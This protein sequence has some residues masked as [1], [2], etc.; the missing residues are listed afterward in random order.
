MIIE[1]KTGITGFVVGFNEEALLKKS[2]T[3]LQG[4]NQLIYVDLNS[5]DNSVEVAKSLS[6]SVIH[7]DRVP[8]VEII[9][10]KL[11]PVCAYDWIL[12]TDPD[13][14]VDEDLKTQLMAL[15]AD[16]PSDIGMVI[17][18]WRFYFKNHPLKGT[19]W[20]GKNYRVV[21]I[22]RN[23]V[24]FSAQVHRGRNLVD[25]FK[26]YV[27]EENGNN[28]I[29]HYWMLSYKQLI[30][31]HRRYIKREGESMYSNGYRFNLW[32]FIKLPVSA[33]RECFIIKKGYKDG[34]IGF[35]LSLFWAWYKISAYISLY[36]FQK[37]QEQS[38]F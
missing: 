3:N 5:S 36:Q 34:I 31:K 15:A 26:Q 18:P 38:Q 21:L 24:E 22:N 8:I 20:G 4:L 7:H 29:H 1:E 32:S 25:G 28:I 6:A 23:R 16:N 13:E 10:S 17:A 33:F 35:N 2:L 30:E 27:I 37:K 19:I 9:H 14:V 12:I 11:L